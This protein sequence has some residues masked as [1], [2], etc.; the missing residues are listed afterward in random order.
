VTPLTNF[1][2]QAG[3]YYLIKEAAGAAGT[4]DLPTADQTGTIAMGAT[5]GKVALVS[6]T[7][8]LAGTC[9]TGSG[10][11]D[12]IGYDGA[13]CFE[14]ANPAPTL[15]NP[16]AALRKNDGCLD[17][18]NNGTTSCRARPT[19]ATAHRRRTIAPSYRAS[20][21]QVH[22]AYNQEIVRRSR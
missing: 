2:L 4:V 13:N 7:T 5:S 6:N 21:R 12:F 9:P 18:D 10:I 16:T 3:Q 14:G 15:T 11:V 19:R 8:A 17:T 22:S 1:T 20:G